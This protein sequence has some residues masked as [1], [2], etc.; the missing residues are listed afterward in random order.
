[1]RL[2]NVEANLL[3]LWILTAICHDW[4]ADAKIHFTEYLDRIC[5]TNVPRFVSQT[6]LKFMAV[7]IFGRAYNPRGLLDV[8]QALEN[9]NKVEDLLPIMK[10]RTKNRIRNFSDINR[11][12]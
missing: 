12:P 5:S 8:R 3:Q 4:L 6:F 11:V 1:M 9:V 7:V 2:Y 10:V